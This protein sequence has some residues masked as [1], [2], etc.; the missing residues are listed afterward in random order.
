MSIVVGVFCDLSSALSLQVWVILWDHC[1]FLCGLFFSMSSLGVAMSSTVVP[2]LP[3]FAPKDAMGSW[4]SCAALHRFTWAV[5]RWGLSSSIL[6]AV[7]GRSSLA[8]WLCN[9]GLCSWVV[10]PPGVLSADDGIMNWIVF[11][12]ESGSTPLGGLGLD[13]S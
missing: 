1:F 13:F 3:D 9:L 2:P 7:P 5:R 12:V 4:T 6:E 11:S 10:D 8:V